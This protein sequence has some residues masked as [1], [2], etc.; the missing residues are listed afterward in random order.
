MIENRL[1]SQTRIFGDAGLVMLSGECGFSNAQSIEQ[2]M[3]GAVDS[4]ARHLIVDL[5]EASFLDSSTMQAL[6]L[7]GARM[8]AAGGDVCLVGGQDLRRLLTIAGDDQAFTLAES[9]SEALRI[10]AARSRFAAGGA[11]RL[12]PRESGLRFLDERWAKTAASSPKMP[13]LAA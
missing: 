7:T 10:V 2:V 12:R 8:E 6:F 1:S 3:L 11:P 9:L 13:P 5:G 4:G